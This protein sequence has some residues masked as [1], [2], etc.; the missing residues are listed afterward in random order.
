LETART[1]LRALVETQVTAAELERARSEATAIINKASAEPNAVA[2]AWLDAESYRLDTGADPARAFAKLTPA[3]LQRV[4]AR[5]FR[6][7]SFASIALGS[8][9]QLKSDLE[10]AGK[11]EVIGQEVQAVPPTPAP[12]PKSP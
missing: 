6:G 10:R 5:L 1:V 4:A 9:A 11:V 8:A 3:D 7:V 12:Q 2:E